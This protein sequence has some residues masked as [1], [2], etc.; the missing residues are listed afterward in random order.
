LLIK[1]G[2]EKKKITMYG[3]STERTTR[4]SEKTRQYYSRAK[5]VT[6]PPQREQRRKKRDSLTRD[7]TTGRWGLVLAAGCW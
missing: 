7:L 4:I 3:T 5:A 2:K 6:E 1:E